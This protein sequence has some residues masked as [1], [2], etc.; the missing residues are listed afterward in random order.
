MPACEARHAASVRDRLKPVP[1]LPLLVV[2]GD[3][4]A[5]RAYHGV[6][7]TIVRAEGRPAGAIV[8]FATML[9]RLW[10]AGSSR[11]ALGG[12]HTLH[13]PPCRHVALAVYTRGR[14]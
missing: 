4:L 3:S 2:D 5:H 7:K 13:V 14:E 10:E 12:W 6:P 9:V 11:A 1:R 8:G